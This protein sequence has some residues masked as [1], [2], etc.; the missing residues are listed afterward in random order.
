MSVRCRWLLEVQGESQRWTERRLV[1]RSLRHAKASE[2]TLRARVAQAKAQVEALNQ[3]G[4]GR[5]RFEEID[6]LRLAVN[7]IVQRIKSPT[8]YGYAT[9]NKTRLRPVRA[10]RDRAAGS[11][12]DRQATVEVRVDEEAL[13]LAV[14]RLG[15][16]VYV[17]NQ[18]Q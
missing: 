16:R 10:Y 9:I 4:R 12:I 17:T 5:K 1:I 14:S 11:K 2:A 18:P 15:W 13:D 3:R 8:F 7:A 6:E